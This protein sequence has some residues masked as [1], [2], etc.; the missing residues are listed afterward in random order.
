MYNGTVELVDVT[1]INIQKSLVKVEGYDPA[2]ATIPME[3]GNVT[4]NLSCKTN[5]GISVE[6]PDEAKSWLGI[7]SVTGGARRNL[8]CQ[9]Q[10][11]WR[12]QHYRSVQDHR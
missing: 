12:P 11:W 10:Q 5:N 4:V 9:C 1:V 2:D 8:P 3:G 7:V 6:I